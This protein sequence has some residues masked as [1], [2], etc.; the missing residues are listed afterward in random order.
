MQARTKITQMIAECAA[1]KNAGHREKAIRSHE[2]VQKY[3]HRIDAIP[4][5]GIALFS[6]GTTLYSAAVVG[7]KKS[8]FACDGKFFTALVA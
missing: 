8:V 6:D 5:G 3:L 1:I 4:V 7:E 2:L